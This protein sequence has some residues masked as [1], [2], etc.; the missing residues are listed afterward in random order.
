MSAEPWKEFE[1]DR[2]VLALSGFDPADPSPDWS[3]AGRVH[4][5]R[6]HVGEHT[7]TIWRELTQRQRIAL[8]LDADELAGREEW[9]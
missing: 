1:P 6:N 4:D 9:E 5:W 7:K 8:A 2:N 3:L